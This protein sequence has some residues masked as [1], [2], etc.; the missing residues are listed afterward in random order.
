MENQKERI[1]ENASKLFIRYGI[2]SI[3]MDEVADSQ[4]ISKRTLYEHFTN[5]Q[6]LLKE[7]IDYNYQLSIEQR[8]ELKNRYPDDPLE[9]IYRTFRNIMINLNNMHPGFITDIQK[10]HSTLWKEHIESN[11]KEN[12]EFTKTII[13]K[14]V[15][16]G[17]F[18]QK[19]NTDL[20]SVW[21]H[22]LMQQLHQTEILP[23]T[24]FQKT[25]VFQ[26]LIL[27]FIRG[28]ATVEGL[29]KIDEKF[30]WNA[31]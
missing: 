5:K 13:A 27:N 3:T 14:G 7:C 23:E 2:K 16:Q 26:Q 6:E 12:I 9:I 21:I 1:V 31:K 22:N 18:H 25:E 4:G 20:L 30:D 24:Q 15:K 11:Q 8:D 19:I 17:I 29:K 28:M 10:Y